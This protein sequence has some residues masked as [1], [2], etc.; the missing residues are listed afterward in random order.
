MPPKST[1]LASNESIKQSLS[2]EACSLSTVNLL[3]E[4]LFSSQS[5]V[6][7]STAATKSRTA[8]TAVSKAA[9]SRKT[10]SKEICTAA[11]GPS[12]AERYK[13]A[14]EVINS[15]LRALSDAAKKLAVSQVSSTTQSNP[16]LKETTATRKPTKPTSNAR[17]LQSRSLNRTDHAAPTKPD[18]LLHLATCA[19]VAV[20]YLYSIEKTSD[21]PPF[22]P[23]Q[24][25]NAQSTL[26]SKLV[27]LGMFEVALKEGRKLRRRMEEMMQ[28][29]SIG[30]SWVAG[31]NTDE[32]VRGGKAGIAKTKATKSSSGKDNLADAEQK[33]EKETVGNLLEFKNVVTTIPAFPLVISCQLGLLRSI[34]GLNKPEY[35]EAI[36]PS[37]SSSNGP[38]ALI[39][40]LARSSAS[41][42]S[43]HLHALHHALL[44]TAPSTT[45][46]ADVTACNS[47]I[48]CSPRTALI[49]HTM[50]VECAILKKVIQP[51][52]KNVKSVEDKEHWEMLRK[53]LAAYARRTEDQQSKRERYLAIRDAAEKIRRLIHGKESTNPFPIE[54][55]KILSSVSAETGYAKECIRW[56]GEWLQALE[57]LND[58]LDGA[59]I[60][61][62]KVKIATME[63]KI[64]STDADGKIISESGAVNV[65]KDK[66][67]DAV[68]G[69]KTVSK[70]RKQDLEQLLQE[71]A[72]MRRSSISLL[73][74]IIRELNKEETNEEKNEETTPQ[75]SE[76]EKEMRNELRRAS[77]KIT[78][79]VIAFC[80][81]YLAMDISSEERSRAEMIALPAIDTVLSTAWRGFDP[82]SEESWDSVE[83]MLRDC[84]LLKKALKKEGEDENDVFYEK[85]SNAYWQVFLAYRKTGMDKPSV[86][87]LRKS[88]AIMDGRNSA[89]LRRASVALKCER[90]GSFFLGVGD[91]HKAEDALLS[92]I[93]AFAD[94]GVLNE[95]GESA[96]RGEF[97]LED[98]E[99][100]NRDE[101]TVGRVLAGLVKCASKLRD[102][103]VSG[104]RFGDLGISEAARGILLEWSFKTVTGVLGHDGTI[105]RAI[106]E[107]LLNVY[108]LDEMPLRRAR[109]V[110]KLLAL[111]VDRAE[112]LNRSEVA[113][114]GDEI[115]EWADGDGSY[116]QDKG[117][118][119]YT[120]DIIAGCFV[121]QAL[122][123]WQ[124]D[125][126]RPD[127][128]MKAVAIWTQLI[129]DSAKWETVLERVEDIEAVVK[130][131]EMLVEFSEV[132][133]EV[134]LRVA[135]LR[136]LL[137]FRGIQN[138]ANFDALV[139]LQSSLGVQ[140]L[141]L[142]YSGKAG[143]ALAKAQ[144]YVN[145]SQAEISATTLLQWHLGYT[146]Y[147]V[148]IGN[149]EKAKEHFKAANEIV[150]NDEELL[151]AKKSGAQIAKRVRINRAIADAAYVTSLLAYEQGN[152]NDS[153]THIRRSIRLNQR[154]WAGLECLSKDQPIS[155]FAKKAKD[156]VEVL[157]ENME[158]L[159]T[160]EF[161]RVKVHSTT[162]DA[163][164]I[165]MLW[166]I[167]SALYLSMIQAST[168]Y[169]HQGMSREAEFFIE[170][171]LRTVE[172][173]DATPMVA[174]A[175]TLFG[176]LKIRAGEVDE[177]Q[178]MLEEAAKKIKEGRDS[179]EL[180]LAIGNLGKVRGDV[181]L[182]EESYERAKLWLEKLVGAERSSGQEGTDA[183]LTDK[184][185]NM[186]LAENATRS[187]GKALLRQTNSKGKGTTI[188]RT[189]GT[190]RANPTTAPPSK[191]NTVTGECSALLKLKGNVL[192]MKSYNQTIQ[193]NFEQAAELL[194]QAAMLPAGQQEYISQGLAEAKQLLHEA[195]E[196]IASDPVF[197]VLQDSTLSV[198]SIAASS[199]ADSSPT[200]SPKKLTRKTIVTVPKQARQFVDFLSK[201]RDCIHNVHI[202]AVRT[203]STTMA[204]GVASLL[205]GVIV[206][207]SAVSNIKGK[208]AEHPLYASYSLELN[209]GLAL[210]REKAA[211]EAEKAVLDSKDNLSWPSLD[212]HFSSVYTVPFDFSSF[213]K[214]YIDIIPKRWAAVSISLSEN[215]EELYI[216][217]FQTGQSQFMVRL[218]LTRHNSR[219]E[220]NDVFEFDTG[221]DE[222][223]EIIEDA[224]AST[225]AAK[226][227]TSKAARSEWW[228]KREEIDGRLKD[229][230]V[231]IEHVWLGGFK[232]ILSQY[233]RHPALLARFRAS[234]DKILGKHLPSR[235]KKKAGKVGI[236]HR[237]LELFIGL[238]SP[239]GQ[240]LE[241]A[242]VDLIYF[243]VD[244]LQFHGEGNA[245]DE[246]DV[247]AIAEELTE[248]LALYHEGASFHPGE[249]DEPVDHTILI[250]DRSVQMFPWESLPC[251]RGHSVSRLPSLAS[252][253]DRI[254]MM[255]ERTPK[256]RN[257]GYYVNKSSGAYILNPSSDLKSTQKFF[258]EDLK[259]LENWD[260]I[261]ERAPSEEEFKLSLEKRDIM[262]YFGHGSGAH[263]IRA[264]TVKK[265]DKCAVSFLLG[266]SSGALKDAGEFEPYGMAANYM[267]GGCPALVA[268]LWD[269]TDKDIDRFSKDVF[270]RWGLFRSAA[271]KSRQK[272]KGRE[273]MD[274]G[275]GVSLVEAVAKGRESC[276]L[277]YLNGAAPVV[278]G[279]PAYLE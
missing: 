189:P 65:I 278:Y 163:L 186:E 24:I 82:R 95:F 70:G 75:K 270:E 10:T 169:R 66:V 111:S 98:F 109:V 161:A 64:S 36:I 133:G 47:K 134:E 120:D 132:K 51:D 100:A 42:A 139:K 57:D 2:A 178:K 263:F 149:I 151:N 255:Q 121:S 207:L 127:M 260:G 63:L 257:P 90:L 196:A 104:L 46:A 40:V 69:L 211:I 155:G 170:Q 80:R 237:V 271:E 252:L 200:N 243:V 93:K 171:A 268:T 249:L 156:G 8:R 114:L 198:P 227:M 33:V 86:L 244:I 74:L 38:Y 112:L 219:D 248:A 125:E 142:G 135:V 96:T 123:H 58:P 17:P 119:R 72:L 34:A 45:S 192:R 129:D 150:D 228:A 71:V 167:V 61:I 53:C 108:D 126:A 118:G 26:I 30:D 266:C 105:V 103:T 209:K 124:N 204:H 31:K 23:L 68:D 217:R 3:Q 43:T 6:V 220:F 206:L 202:R 154:A 275:N 56:T 223:R 274:G 27:Q 144:A 251:L 152:C 259:N 32:Q 269:V 94:T 136:L 81:K 175:L 101:A 191:A 21:V 195:L 183:E 180:E 37:L 18:P 279:V 208:G 13:L 235:K 247:D 35:V 19:S 225:H 89:E 262:L 15:C 224:N 182:E 236:D 190:G 188:S 4:A 110:S 67:M 79:S 85:V 141:R 122:L 231:N 216:S 210:Q 172:A 146:E 99:S 78:Q 153:L 226:D 62:C 138:Q 214:E 162:H 22:P 128:I 5:S 265:L 230:L 25:E 130:K 233:P 246:I 203:G 102:D 107:R 264:R 201:A 106:G 39:K 267:L 116:G 221:A 276:V 239:K 48:S 147:L 20:Q 88:I 256:Q 7:A 199:P 184:M 250:L 140:Y 166:P 115:L 55:L 83:S 148:N 194:K 16:P 272:G 91:Y 193:E 29:H 52:E 165:P 11:T 185:A 218:P 240:E 157:V 160:S 261:V 131:L 245:Y 84:N 176:D 159:S 258:Q 54:I 213:Q 238:G 168:I 234:F 242:L 60:V 113:M 212:P 273:G 73:A 87:A 50:I 241:D 76:A 232:G 44:S 222:L 28:S 173:V 197:S 177:G 9:S 92:A 137:S 41:K 174:K 59:A 181:N 277:K 164:N 179:V 49:L 117:L 12:A 97:S 215:H 143:M 254:L 1:A 77:D 14:I 158:T 253:R 229:L 145:K 205:S 187:R